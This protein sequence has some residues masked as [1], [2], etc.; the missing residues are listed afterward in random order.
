[1]GSVAFNYGKETS[2]FLTKMCLTK[3]LL[4]HIFGPI[5]VLGYLSHPDYTNYN[6]DLSPDTPKC[7]WSYKHLHGNASFL[8]LDDDE[9]PK[10]DV[11]NAIFY[12]Y[13]SIASM[14]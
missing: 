9:Y 4:L 13:F 7:A 14:Y 1:M 6:N 5:C 12:H 10:F 11:E 2:T 3:L 8:C